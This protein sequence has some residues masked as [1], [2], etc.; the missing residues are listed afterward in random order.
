VTEHDV[1]AWLARQHHGELDLIIRASGESR[2]SDMGLWEAAWAELHFSPPLW[3]DFSRADLDHA[4]KEF[5]SRRRRF[6]Y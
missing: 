6:G 3:E 5:A 4:V 1:A 2:L